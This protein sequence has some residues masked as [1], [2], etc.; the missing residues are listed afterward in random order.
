[1]RAGWVREAGRPE[2]SRSRTLTPILYCTA[3]CLMVGSAMIAPP[4]QSYAFPGFGD[5]DMC[6]HLVDK[7]P[8]NDAGGPWLH[9]CQLS[10][11]SEI[12][13]D[14]LGRG[15]GG[16]AKPLILDEICLYL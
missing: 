5:G 8:C 11:T 4:N 13:C 6:A 1:M 12:I 16:G 2:M 14:N 9:L 15:E 3:M 7:L 10:A